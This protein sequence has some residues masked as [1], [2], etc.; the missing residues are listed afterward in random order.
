MGIKW[1]KN[2]DEVQLTLVAPVALAGASAD[3]DAERVPFAGRIV[4]CEGALA[5][6][7]GTTTLELNVKRGTTK[8]AI[9]TLNVLPTPAMMT[10]TGDQNVMAGDYLIMDTNATGTTPRLGTLTVTIKRK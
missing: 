4:S 8:T 2:M 1:S 6:G 10:I 9:G 5:S 3:N 7:S